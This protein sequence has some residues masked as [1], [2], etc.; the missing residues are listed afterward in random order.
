MNGDRLDERLD[1]LRHGPSVPLPDRLRHLPAP[2]RE[3]PGLNACRR[4]QVI[5]ML[6]I[7]CVCAALFRSG[8]EGDRRPVD[9]LSFTDA[10][11]PI[12]HSGLNVRL[13]RADHVPIEAWSSTVR[14]DIEGNQLTAQGFIAIG[15]YAP[16]QDAR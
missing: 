6:T 8:G 9:S 13:K 5:A 10:S 12:E 14:H 7:V 4:N 3:R 1:E 11:I 2:R 16:D 15:K